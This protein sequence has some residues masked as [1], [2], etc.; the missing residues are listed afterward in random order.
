[1]TIEKVLWAAQLRRGAIV[2]G[3]EQFWT[4]RIC[5]FP[6]D[7]VVCFEVFDENG[8]SQ[9]NPRTRFICAS[10][11]AQLGSNIPIDFYYVTPTGNGEGTL[12][13]TIGSGL[14]VQATA[15]SPR[16]AL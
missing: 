12:R 10:A 11:T 4:A 6:P 2:K 7:D 8:Q 16:E 1:M 15:S 13:L 3:T 14:T 5:T 9:R